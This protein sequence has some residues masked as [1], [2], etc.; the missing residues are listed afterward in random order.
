MNT[1]TETNTNT[2][3]QADTKVNTQ[4]EEKA[5]IVTSV[6]T[7]KEEPKVILPDVTLVGEPDVKDE[8]EEVSLNFFYV[9]KVLFHIVEKC[10]V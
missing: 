9:F 1:N 7:Q 2:N 4:S 3:T 8:K 6:E 10:M 5:D